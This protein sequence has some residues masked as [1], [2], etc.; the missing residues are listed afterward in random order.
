MSLVGLT[1]ELLDDNKQSIISGD[2]NID[3]IN[4]KMYYKN[5]VSELNKA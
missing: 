1:D 5:N 2:F 3:K 4:D